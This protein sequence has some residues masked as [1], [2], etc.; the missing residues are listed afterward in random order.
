[1]TATEAR[2]QTKRGNL[3]YLASKYLDNIYKLIDKSSKGGLSSCD[4]LINEND[5]CLRYSLVVIQ[6]T[7]F[8]KGFKTKVIFK[9]DKDFLRISW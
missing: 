4:W 6:N 9:D 1:M 8:G 3:F 2:A 5:E 7:L